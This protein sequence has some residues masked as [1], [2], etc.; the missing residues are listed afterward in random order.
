MFKFDPIQHVA[1]PIER[2]EGR[3]QRERGSHLDGLD[4]VLDLEE[5]P[6]RLEGV[7]P[8]VILRPAKTPKHKMQTRQ[9]LSTRRAAAGRLNPK[10]FKDRGI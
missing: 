8:A 6:L 2:Y 10:G 4:G 7:H 3:Q 5:P 9:Q 1:L